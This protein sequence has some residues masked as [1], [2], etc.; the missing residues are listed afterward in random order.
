MT[1]QHDHRTDTAETEAT[2]AEPQDEDKVLDDL[3]PEEEEA[4]RVEAGYQMQD[5]AWGS[6]RV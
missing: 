2:V 5:S 4:E 6:A 3:A 1:Q